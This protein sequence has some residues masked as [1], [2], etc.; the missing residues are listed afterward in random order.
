MACRAVRSSILVLS[1]VLLG[2]VRLQG[3]PNSWPPVEVRSKSRCPNISGTYAGRGETDPPREERLIRTLGVVFSMHASDGIEV[4]QFTDDVLE[5]TL[6][7][8]VDRETQRSGKRVF[9]RTAGDYDCGSVG[10]GLKTE[11]RFDNGANTMGYYG[12]S[13][14]R[15]WLSKSI[16]GALVVKQEASGFG[17]VGPIPIATTVHEWCRFKPYESAAP[18]PKLRA[19][20]L[21]Q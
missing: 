19:P 16:D 21:H 12:W 10:I 8:R 13:S 18:P 1:V 11:S 14:G 17:F 6:L 2:C 4:A 20:D 7:Y 9:I 15:S 5:V 3:Y